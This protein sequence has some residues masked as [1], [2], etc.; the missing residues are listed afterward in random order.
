MLL[1]FGADPGLRNKKREQAA[2]VAASRGHRT[3]ANA[4]Q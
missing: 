3:I 2:D 4:I 1:N